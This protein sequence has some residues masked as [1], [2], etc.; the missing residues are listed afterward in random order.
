M[1]LHRRSGGLR[2]GVHAQTA[3][4]LGEDDIVRFEDGYRRSWSLIGAAQSLGHC[5]LPCLSHDQPQEPPST[6]TQ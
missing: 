2:D 1:R 3:S 6:S 5:E 4:H